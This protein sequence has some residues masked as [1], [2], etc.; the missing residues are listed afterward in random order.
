MTMFENENEQLLPSD[1]ILLDTCTTCTI[2]K[3]ARFM[4]KIRKAATP[5]AVKSTGG[6]VLVELEGYLP[7]LEMWVP[8]SDK[9]VGNIL[10][11]KDVKAKFYTAHD[12]KT[13]DAIF[14]GPAR[15]E[16]EKP[17]RGPTDRPP[18]KQKKIETSLLP[19]ELWDLLF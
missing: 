14:V 1:W 2:F 7:W 5:M 10:A 4:S 18:R 9:S 13:S 16:L 19:C 8:L 17:G 12:S 6:E 3:S 11:F 15:R